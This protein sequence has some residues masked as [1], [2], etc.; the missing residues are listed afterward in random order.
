ML[1][2]HKKIAA[3]L[4]LLVTLAFAFLMSGLFLCIDQ[5]NNF[6]SPILIFFFALILTITSPVI[7]FLLKQQIN[8]IY[9]SRVEFFE[10][11]EQ[12]YLEALGKA[13][14]HNTILSLAWGIIQQCFLPDMFLIYVYVP[15]LDEYLLWD[16]TSQ[17]S[18]DGIHFLPECEFVERLRTVDFLDWSS[19]SSQF[20]EEDQIRVNLMVSRYFYPMISAG[21]LMGW[22]ALGQLNSIQYHSSH[23]SSLLIRICLQTAMALNGVYANEL[24]AM[25]AKKMNVLTKMA[26]GISFTQDLD[27]ILE[28]ITSHMSQIL[29]ADILRITLCQTS[30]GMHYHVFA[31]E[32]N[33][34]ISD[35]EN[36]YFQP[37]VGLET[38][39]MIS[40]LP[41]VT[42]DYRREC[43]ERG[44]ACGL[45]GIYGWLGVPLNAGANTIGVISIASRNPEV[46]FSQDQQKL[47]QAIADLTAG[48]I[49]KL[50]LLDESQTRA[51]QL[52]KL[53]EISLELTSILKPQML[54]EKILCN[55]IG[56]L[57]CEAG[58]LL[59]CDHENDRVSL[60]AVQGSFLDQ[61]IGKKFSN[62]TSLLGMEVITNPEIKYFLDQKHDLDDGFRIFDEEFKI[63]S[64]L[65]VRMQIQ[66]CVSGAIVLVNRKNN[67][68]FDRLDAEWLTIFANQASIALENAHLYSLTDQALAERL[69]ELYVMQQI[70][71]QINTNLEV[72][73]ALQIALEWALKQ[74]QAD[75]GAVGIVD[76]TG[77]RLTAAKGNQL[78]IPLS[79]LSD[80]DLKTRDCFDL[81]V[82][83]E[84][85]RLI[86]FQN[87]DIPNAGEK[88]KGVL[89]HAAKS[90]LAIPIQRENQI[91]GM[92]LLESKFPH[93]FSLTKISFLT[94]LS[95]HTAIALANAK[96]FEEVRE[97]NISKSRFVSFVAHELKNPMS[98]IKGYTELIASG[99]AGPVTETQSKFLATVS[100]NVERMNT[101]VSDLND[102]TK[103]QVGNLKLV[104]AE[105]HVRDVLDEVL[106]SMQGQYDEKGQLL[107]IDLPKNIPAVWADASRLTQIFTNLLSNANKYTPVDGQISIGA[108]LLSGNEQATLE[109][110]HVWVRDNGIGISSEDQK[111]IFQQYFRTEL[112][113][114]I[115]IGTGLGLNITKS[116]VLLH[117][118]EIWFESS[119]GNGS[120]F[121]LKL[122]VF[123]PE[124]PLFNIQQQQTDQS[125]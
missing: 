102:L 111:K 96:L 87:V 105:V 3:L 18:G 117:G 91:I 32:A 72:E 8:H 64:I 81:P 70:D 9:S 76:D 79:S 61:V 1:D 6:T 120:T 107:K 106:R 101:I 35:L 74:S 53:N 97:A 89:I 108:E 21:N 34:R 82:F 113:K 78:A 123:K 121:H 44:K 98:S 55:A 36:K 41:I 14:D 103:I 30:N 20:S 51:T 52:A 75:A 124:P 95:D 15:D 100:S 29:P 125:K 47:L 114:E 85:I 5:K 33:E 109:S 10:T 86:K 11:R 24:I 69:D 16:E 46:N 80:Q 22:L 115:T 4:Y 57:N 48:A 42:R 59:I 66:D 118:G 40:Q 56:F 45:E 112:A 122:P 116:L 63:Q 49:V 50:R 31:S 13:N 38:D 58:Y 77:V 23:P 7:F 12:E 27:D 71:R 73:R 62:Q 104:C 26:Q 119:L 65:A 110:L 28:L 37:D 60:E 84:A 39:V 88:V 93:Y 94:R 43:F 90:Q 99:L 54:Y 92:L 68:P 25:L 2:D 17:I 19:V 67:Q 83:S